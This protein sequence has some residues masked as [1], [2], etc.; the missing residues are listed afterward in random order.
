MKI[1][2]FSGDENTSEI[3]ENNCVQELYSTL[4]STCYNTDFIDYFR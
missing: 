2:G 4:Y 3:S 1:K